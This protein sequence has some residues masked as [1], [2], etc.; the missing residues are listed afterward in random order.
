MQYIYH[1]ILNSKKGILPL[2]LLFVCSLGLWSCKQEDPYVPP[3]EDTSTKDT[4]C[5]VSTSFGNMY[6][7][8]FRGTPLHRANFHKLVAQGFYENTEF[9]RIIPNFMIQGG[10]PLSKDADRSNDGTGGP[11]YLIKAEI[12]TFKYK[13]IVGSVAAA[14]TNNPEKSSSGSQFYIA[15]SESGTKHLNG[16]Y[17]VFGQVIKGVEVAQTIV[18]QPRN[19]NNLPDQRIMMKVKIIPKTH[20]ELIA[21]FGFQGE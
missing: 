10:D 17:T 4:I 19:A 6:L 18:S 20:N 1:M 5:L 2:T 12:D 21:E 7:Y 15:V 13:H 3:I 9:H 8:M 16:Q 14:R 11:G